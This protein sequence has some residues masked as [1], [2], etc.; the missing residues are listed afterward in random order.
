MLL[1][2]PFRRNWRDW[3]A[4][5]TNSSWARLFRSPC[6]RIWLRPSR[7]LRPQTRRPSRRGTLH[8]RPIHHQNLIR[9][10]GRIR[11]S[12]VF[13]LG[14]CLHDHIKQPQLSSVGT[15]KIQTPVVRIDPKH[16]SG[17]VYQRVGDRVSVVRLL[18]INR[19][20]RHEWRDVDVGDDGLVFWKE[21]G[22]VE[23]G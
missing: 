19:K 9:I 8:T 11:R 18:G 12:R 4:S 10:L 7:W 2:I 23:L 22:D 21:F 3:L 5:W 20:D 16:L 15:T 1:S 13:I 14:R 17:V 6:S